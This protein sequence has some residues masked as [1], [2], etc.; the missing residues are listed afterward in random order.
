MYKPSLKDGGGGSI[1]IFKVL[2]YT[3]VQVQVCVKVKNK[4]WSIKSIEMPPEY[5][6]LYIIIVHVKAG[7]YCFT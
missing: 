1:Q 2:H 6:M 3:E 7:F 4:P 5:F